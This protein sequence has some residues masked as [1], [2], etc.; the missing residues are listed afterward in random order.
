MNNLADATSGIMSLEERIETITDLYN[1]FQSL[2]Q[3]PPALLRP[4]VTPDLSS[5]LV[6]LRPDISNLK[7]VGELIRS[8]KVQEALRVARASEKA[9]KSELNSNSRRK[10]RK[11]RCVRNLYHRFIC[12]T[13]KL[14]QATTF[15]RVT[16]AVCVIS[17][18]DYIYVSHK[19]R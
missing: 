3:I 4:P 17:A 16:A 10:C 13:L 12:I 7:E 11:R 5:S 9:D 14:I 1:R 8:D 6:S 15:T 19:Y 2:R 18:Q